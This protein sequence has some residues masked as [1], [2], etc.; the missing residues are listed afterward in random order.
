MARKPGYA[1]WFAHRIKASIWPEW[2]ADSEGTKGG[3]RG[4]KN[5]V[6]L[7]RSTRVTLEGAHLAKARRGPSSVDV[8]VCRSCIA[9][10]VH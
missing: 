1:W 2:S 6:A 5:E 9:S 3:G 10:V 8:C 7:R 4:V